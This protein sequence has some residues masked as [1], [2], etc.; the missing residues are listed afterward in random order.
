[1]KRTVPM[2]DKQADLFGYAGSIAHAA[3]QVLSAEAAARAQD[4]AAVGT[5]IG[6]IGAALDMSREQTLA[7]IANL[8]FMDFLA[9]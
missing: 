9:K 6:A 7:I 2:P 3:P 8:D 5:D 4:G 1:M